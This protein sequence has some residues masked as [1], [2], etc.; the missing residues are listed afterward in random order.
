MQGHKQNSETE[1]NFP[2][3]P[4]PSQNARASHV[5]QRVSLKLIYIYIIIGM[6]SRR[7]SLS[8]TDLR[9]PT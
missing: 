3:P 4:C 9:K 2:K 5:F 6:I 8:Q 7:V 1:N